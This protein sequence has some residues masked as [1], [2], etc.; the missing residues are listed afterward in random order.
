ML[1]FALVTLGTD[2]PE[3]RAPL[4][5]AGNG[6]VA[7]SHGLRGPL[8]HRAECRSQQPRI[9]AWPSCWSV[10]Q[11][12][13][14]I[15]T[16]LEQVTRNM[17]HMQ[18][19]ARLL[20]PPLAVGSHVKGCTL[21]KSDQSGTVAPKAKTTPTA[22]TPI[23]RAKLSLYTPRP[24]AAPAATSNTIKQVRSARAWPRKS[25]QASNRLVLEQAA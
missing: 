17:A 20:S 11:T 8:V 18:L 23:I 2:H 5:R 3:C 22:Y 7:R 4:R 10:L 21:L 9:I 6:G 15:V 12:G 25:I 14:P 19:A 24:K 13:H 1:L 16:R